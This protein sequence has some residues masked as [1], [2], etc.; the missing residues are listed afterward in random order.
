MQLQF[1]PGSTS[2][3]RPFDAARHGSKSG[4][5]KVVLLS[6]PLFA[7]AVVAYDAAGPYAESIVRIRNPGFG[8]ADPPSWL[9]GLT[10]SWLD[11]PG[12]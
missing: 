11:L 7:A 9:L 8:Q 3:W 5:E 4:G 6:Q 1:R 10:H 2:R 12:G